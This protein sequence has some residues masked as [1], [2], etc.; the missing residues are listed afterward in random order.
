MKL[1]LLTALAVTLVAAIVAAGASA[2]PAPGM[3][4]ARASSEIE[5]HIRLVVPAVVAKAQDTLRLYKQLGGQGGIANARAE[6]KAAQAGFEVDHASCLGTKAA[7]GGWSAFRC[8]LSLSDDLGF[9]AKAQGTYTRTAGVWRWWTTS[10]TLI[11]YGP[12]NEPV[13]LGDKFPITVVR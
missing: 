12:W 10:F 4:L 6:L 11:G 2:A 5:F 1:R 8:K 9:T 3:S 7:A 13:H